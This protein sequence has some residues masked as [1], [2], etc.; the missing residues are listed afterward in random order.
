MKNSMRIIFASVFVLS[1]QLIFMSSSLLARNCPTNRTHLT[2]RSHGVNI[3]LEKTA[4][5]PNLVNRDTQQAYGGSVQATFFLER[6]TEQGAI[7]RY[8]MFPST[9]KPSCGPCKGECASVVLPRTATWDPA[10]GGAYVADA[11]GA[12]STADLDLGFL[13]H[14]AF[15]G[16]TSNTFPG[17]VGP[18]SSTELR[19]CPEHNAMGVTFNYHQDLRC[20]LKGLYL[21]VAVPVVSIENSLGME[22]FGAEKDELSKFFYGTKAEIPQGRFIDNANAFV[23]LTKAKISMC[24]RTETLVADVDLMLGYKV[25]NKPNGQASINIGLTIPTGNT[26][27]GEYVFDAIVGN[28][29]H[30]GFGVGFDSRIL[31]W[32]NVRCFDSFALNVAANYRYLFRNGETRTFGLIIDGQRLNFGQYHLLIDRTQQPGSSLPNATPPTTGQQLIPAA[33]L[34]TLRAD[35]T[36]GSQFDG[37]ISCNGN[38]GNFTFDIG[39]NLFARAREKVCINPY[40]AEAQF[41][42]GKWAIATRNADMRVN[43]LDL[44]MTIENAPDHIYKYVNRENLD[45]N[46]ARTKLFVTHKLFM[47]AGYFTKDWSMPLMLG[48]GTHVEWSDCSLINMWGFNARVGLGF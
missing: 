1:A 5:W 28:G 13:M 21:Q 30:L 40:C 11:R 2:P 15:T 14:S 22:T 44:P 45:V 17:N 35:V 34:T 8:F 16:D 18:S 29:N 19:F 46:T 10:G 38:H 9:A 31:L 23:N 42:D 20:L 43:T 6:A 32:Q 25:M 24:S 41:P 4:P 36:P 3:A 7:A 39:Y 47:G 48:I 27:N 26:P 12:G 33:N 37:M